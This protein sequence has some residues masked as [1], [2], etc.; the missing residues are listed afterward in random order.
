MRLS[1]LSTGL[2]LCALLVSCAPPSIDPRQGFAWLDSKSGEAEM[3]L[4]GSWESVDPFVSGGWGN[5]SLLQKGTQV[6]G[7]LG[8]YSIEG[9]VIGKKV[10]VM[11][12]SGGRV[13]YTSILEP[14][15]EGG[16]SGLAVAR[17]LA[18]DP[19]ARFAEHAPIRLVRPITK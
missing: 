2:I 19:E 8:L 10:Y 5:G 9:K 16:L 1:T 3:D 14:T 15:P 6:S 7:S 13:Y 4:S 18:D 12:L 11:I 17:M